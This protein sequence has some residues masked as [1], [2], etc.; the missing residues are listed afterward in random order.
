MLT[1]LREK[2]KGE[3]LFPGED[4]K[5]YKN[6]KKSFKNAVKKAGI[7]NFRFHDLRHTFASHLVMA[8]VD[9]MT[10]KELLG[11]KKLDMTLRYSHLAPD[12]K[13]KAIENLSLIW[14]KESD[15]LA[16]PINSET[17]VVIANEKNS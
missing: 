9:I 15:T 17:L 1:E 13:R 11:H 2:N 4:G 7:I 10:V 16:T 8:G 14:G 5:P 12:H 3:Y 6:I